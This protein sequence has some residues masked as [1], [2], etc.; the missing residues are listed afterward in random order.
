MRNSSEFQQIISYKFRNIDLL[1]C[2]L[3]HSSLVREKDESC[4]ADNERLEFLGDAFLDAIIGEALYVRF[5]ESEEGFLS[6]TRATIVCEKSLAKEGRSLNIGD[7]L[8]LG[9]GEEISGGRGRDSIIADAMEAVIGAMYLDG[10]YEKTKAYVLDVFQGAIRDALEGKIDI[11]DYKSELQ[12][13]LQAKGVL[14]ICYRLENTTG[15]DH[16][17][18]FFVVL[19]V[20]GKAV[21]HGTGKSKKKAEQNAAK[22]G[23]ERG[24]GCTLSD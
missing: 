15:P 23:I 17:K 14:D 12:E 5:P 8:N 20:N 18:R 9:R 19:Q 24:L 6:K 3:T 22:D 7:Y 16:D 10:G 2:A 21:G 13:M 11:Q 1:N 4:L